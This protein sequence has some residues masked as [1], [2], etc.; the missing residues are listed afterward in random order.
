MACA[1]STLA[2]LWLAAALLAPC[3]TS[4]A[5]TR[6]HVATICRGFS[7]KMV[8]NL[9]RMLGSMLNHSRDV[10]VH[11]VVLTDPASMATVAATV[12]GVYSKHLTEGVVFGYEHTRVTIDT[13]VL[14]QLEWF[15]HLKCHFRC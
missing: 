3:V 2:A 13:E 11:L 8:S 12:S 4:A 7:A 14:G 15:H 6:V 5:L 1:V 10:L 9:R